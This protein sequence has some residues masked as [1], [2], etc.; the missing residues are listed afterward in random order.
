MAGIHLVVM[1]LSLFF[2]LVVL[3]YRKPVQQSQE[4]V[5][6]GNLNLRV[7]FT[8]FRFHYHLP[9]S[10]LWCQ[11]P[12]KMTDIFLLAA[13]P[14]HR[15]VWT[16][17]HQCC[18]CCYPSSGWWGTNFSV[19]IVGHRYLNVGFNYIWELCLISPF[20]MELPFEFLC[21][22][23]QTAYCFSLLICQ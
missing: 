11:T 12:M 10:W 18:F 3:I 13:S 15:K 4:Q 7:G 19:E 2:W 23:S 17:S 8:E 1:C 20:Q 22:T 21:F 5:F 6:M 14:S 16:C 9:N